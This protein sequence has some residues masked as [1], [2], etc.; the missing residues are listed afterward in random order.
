MTNY[1]EEVVVITGASA[2][3]G[4]AIA[5]EFGR[6]GAKVGV[7]ARGRAGLQAAKEEIE[8]LGGQA[9]A[10]P[11]DVSDAEAVEKAAQEVE[12]T[13]G[14]IDV[15]INNAMLS[16]FSPVHEMEPEE[17]RRVTEVNY[18]G[19]VYGTLAALKRMR[20]RNSGSIILVGSALAYRGIPLQSA[21]CG[22]KHAAQGFFDSLRSE[23]LHEK[24][25]VRLTMVQ[26]PAMN[27]TQFGWVKNRLG[28]KARPM[29]KIFQPEVAA[30]AIFYAAHH[31]RREIYVALPTVK[32][33]LGDRA[34]P[35]AGDLVLAKNGFKGQMTDEPLPENYRHNLWE[36]L[37]DEQDY[38]SHGSFDH[39][40]QDNSAQAWATTHRG[41]ATAIGSFAAIALGSLAWVLLKT[42]GRKEE[43]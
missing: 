7:L 20:P 10:I 15:W 17:Y 33:V 42:R 8:A 39:L 31:D 12:E 19:Q 16:V 14:A 5:R 4:R 11:C 3:L 1:S 30:R 21:Y 27:T 43:E 41:F 36:P 23:L 18:L 6:Q 22:S 9:V 35:W 25:K 37:D 13:F 2:G 40:A 24:S 34:A 32:A 26:L 28:K 38:G 29:G